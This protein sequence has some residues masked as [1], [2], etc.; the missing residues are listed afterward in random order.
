MSLSQ[1][2]RRLLATSMASNPESKE[3]CDAVDA[4]TTAGALN[5]TFRTN[6]TATEAEINRACDVSG[7]VVA[8]GASA[9]A[10]AITATVNGGR[11]LLVNS[12]VPCAI[13][14]PAASGSFEK[15][16]IRLSVAATATPHTISVSTTTGAFAGVSVIAQSDT[17]QVWGFQTTATDNTISLNGTTKGGLVGDKIELIDIAASK[18]QVTIVGGASGTVATPFS[19]V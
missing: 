18:W 14:L 11:V 8:V 17:A 3:I 12:T 15:Y 10:Y 16:E 1:L 6:I 5:T 13:T 19:H 4:N 9:T 2:S 7:R